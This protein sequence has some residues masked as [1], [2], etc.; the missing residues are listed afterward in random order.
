MPELPEVEVVRSG[1]ARW[2]A[3]RTIADVDV[4]LARSIRHHVAGPTDFVDRLRGRTVE[5]VERRGKFLWLTLDDGEA[6]LAH[7]GMSGQLLMQPQGEPDEKHLHVRIGF[8]D[9]GR[10]LR[11]VDQRTFGGLRIEALVR[12]PW[13]GRWVPESVHHIAPDPFEPG[14]DLI[15]VTKR[16]RGRQTGIK[17][18]LLDQ[19]LISGIGNIYADEALWLARRH[20]ARPTSSFTRP[21]VAELVGHATDVMAAALAQGG[22]SFDSLYVDV[23][24]SS[25]YFERSLNVYGREAL[26]CG[27]CGRGIVREPFMNRSSFRCP[28]CQRTP[29]N[30]HW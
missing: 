20:F 2:V 17:R 21:Q 22:T 7:L 27:R 3:G 23:N 25:G 11:F 8:T 16:L 6:L 1:L 19:S 13:A 24:G 9:A 15:A 29:P 10:E 30:A 18:A 26:P 14:F 4:T 28:Q 5:S 12:E